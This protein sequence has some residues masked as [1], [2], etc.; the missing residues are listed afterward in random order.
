AEG[1]RNAGLKVFDSAG[2]YFIVADVTPLG[3]D[4]GTEYCMGLPVLQGVAAIPLA[5]FSDAKG[6]WKPLVRFAF[7]ERDDAVAEG[8]ERLAETPLFR[9]EFLYAENTM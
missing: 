4:D 8:A 9:L 2:T 7:C 3:F 6:R 5:G 1:L